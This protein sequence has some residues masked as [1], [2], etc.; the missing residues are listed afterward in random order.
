MIHRLSP[1][2]SGIDA[3]ENGYFVSKNALLGILSNNAVQPSNIINIP[4]L[5][6]IDEDK[7]AGYLV[8]E[9]LLTIPGYC[10]E[11]WGGVEA[12]S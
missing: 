2:V 5:K 12:L 11:K 7:L 9:L 1:L 10:H 8:P 3:L 6:I 4:L